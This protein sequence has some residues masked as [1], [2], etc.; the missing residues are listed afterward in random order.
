MADETLCKGVCSSSN[1]VLKFIN[2]DVSSIK[3]DIKEI[4]KNLCEHMSRTAAN[5]I[6]VEI[7][8]K[9]VEETM[10]NQQKNFD[11]ILK[12]NAE[13]VKALNDQ[14]KISLGVLAGIATI[15]TAIAAWLAH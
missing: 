12:A 8:E 2:A 1:E 13:N 10:E 6:R 9:F 14:L 15:I 7:M 5:E 4:Q 11:A 3:V